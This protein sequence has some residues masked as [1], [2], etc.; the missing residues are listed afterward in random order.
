MAAGMFVLK[1]RQQMS[2]TATGSDNSDRK[3]GAES[4]S[5]L[6][7]HLTPL[8]PTGGVLPGDNVP[9]NR[10]WIRSVIVNCSF[11]GGQMIVE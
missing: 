5:A 6:C 10:L 9:V 2:V 1:H 11:E 3:L 4:S 7:A 8:P